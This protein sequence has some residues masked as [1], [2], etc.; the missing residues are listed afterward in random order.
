MTN[1]PE[2]DILTS[3]IDPLVLEIFLFKNNY[4]ILKMVFKILFET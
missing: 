4:F 2:E 3:V 1:K